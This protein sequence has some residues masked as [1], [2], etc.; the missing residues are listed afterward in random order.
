MSRQRFYCHKHTHSS[1]T[2][3]LEHSLKRQRCKNSRLHL[4]RDFPRVN[5]I[6]KRNATHGY[7]HILFLR[8]FNP[9]TYVY[10]VDTNAHN[11]LRWRNGEKKKIYDSNVFS[12]FQHRTILRT[13]A[14]STHISHNEI[15]NYALGRLKT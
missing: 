4:V 13:V 15:V 10:I 7:V 9:Q 11:N 2:A 14:T 6:Q 3:I 8:K 1:H 5:E 12:S